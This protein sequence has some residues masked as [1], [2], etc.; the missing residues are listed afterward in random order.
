MEIGAARSD[1][2]V[3]VSADLAPLLD[4]IRLLAEE[5]LDAPAER[6]LD[7]M[8]H[9]LTDGYAL[10][11]ALEGQSLRIEKEIAV[12]LARV[13]DGGASTGLEALADRLAATERDLRSLR[14]HLASLRI[15]TETV[16]ATAFTARV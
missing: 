15:R 8:E 9:T 11:L 13:K 3:A 10:A 6:L 1:N 14:A 7:R 5:P 12:T 2:R 4:R 16:R